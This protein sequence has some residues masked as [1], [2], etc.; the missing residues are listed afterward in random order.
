MYYIWP[1]LA[2]LRAQREIKKTRKEKE[3][4]SFLNVSRKKI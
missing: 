3:V 4:G 1:S 2:L